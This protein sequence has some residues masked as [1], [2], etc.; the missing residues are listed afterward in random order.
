MS[1]RANDPG[2]K[3]KPGRDFGGTFCCG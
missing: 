1:R 2:A 3:Q